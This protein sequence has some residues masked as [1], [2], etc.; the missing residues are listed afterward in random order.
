MFSIA[1]AVDGRAE[2]DPVAHE[3]RFRRLAGKEAE[4]RQIADGVTGDDGGKSGGK[5][6]AVRRLEA[7]QPGSRRA[8]RIAGR[9]A[10]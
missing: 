2:R 3:G 6:Q 1:S 8:S 9:R 10:R 5:W 4:R 7:E